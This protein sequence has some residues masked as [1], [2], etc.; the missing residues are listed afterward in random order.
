M[1]VY[2]LSFA[3]SEYKSI[4][5]II[6]EAVDSKMFDVVIGGDFKKMFK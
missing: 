5:R 6:R 3:N 2:F 1:G 4:N